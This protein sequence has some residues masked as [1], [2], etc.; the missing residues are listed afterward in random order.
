MHQTDFYRLM[1]LTFRTERVATATEITDQFYGNSTDAAANQMNNS[2]R[3]S[4]H[5]LESDEGKQ[6]NLRA[7]NEVLKTDN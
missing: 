2:I 6:S 3:T 4:F 1:F 7:L 5:E